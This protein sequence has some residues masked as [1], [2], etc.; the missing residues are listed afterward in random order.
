[1][2]NSKE[3]SINDKSIHERV[4][5]AISQGMPQCVAGFLLSLSNSEKNEVWEWADS[6]SEVSEE[7]IS[8]VYN[9]RYEDD[10][11]TCLTWP[12]DGKKPIVLT[13]TYNGS[14][15]VP[16][17]RIDKD[18]EY[19][20]HGVKTS[21]AWLLNHF[22]GTIDRLVNPDSSKYDPKPTPID[23][24]YNLV[25]NEAFKNLE[26]YFVVEMPD[27]SIHTHCIHSFKVRNKH[28]KELYFVVEILDEDGKQLGNAQVLPM[29][30][31]LGVWVRNLAY[32][33][34]AEALRRLS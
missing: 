25:G 11:L 24:L 34:H 18:C 14:E 15:F 17:C 29:N 27:K 6:H 3:L 26:C 12:D 9:P 28:H 31:A 21:G 33:E 32:P 13:I 16:S 4:N 7:I 5:H 20:I 1:M 23:K 30:N 8:L 2:K 10:T 22:A 19:V